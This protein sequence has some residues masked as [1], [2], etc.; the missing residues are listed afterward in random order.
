KIPAAFGKDDEQFARDLASQAKVG[1]TPGSA[2]GAG[3]EGYIR[4]SYASS[5][6]DI[7]ECLKRIASFVEK[8]AG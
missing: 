6:A 3:G 1:V 5:E 8:I 4:L 2:F 7:Q